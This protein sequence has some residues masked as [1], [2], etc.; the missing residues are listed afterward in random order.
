MK[1]I[2]VSFYCIIGKDYMRAVLVY[3]MQCVR[4]GAIRKQYRFY[5][6]LETIFVDLK[7]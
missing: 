6:Y 4:C 1:R 5:M 7:I 3:K 2:I